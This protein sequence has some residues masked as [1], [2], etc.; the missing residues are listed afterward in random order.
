MRLHPYTKERLKLNIIIVIRQMS[1]NL[2][3]LNL[4]TLKVTYW[5]NNMKTIYIAGPMRGY[6]CYNFETF[7]YWAKLLK[8][9][10]WRVLNPAQQDVEKML[11]GWVY[12]DDKWQE[13]IEEDLAWIEKEAD[14]IFL[15]DG[16]HR[17]RGRDGVVVRH[18]RCVDIAHRLGWLPVQCSAQC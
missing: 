4:V 2:I 13:V 7:F 11:K 1:G 15:M 8:R 16:W 14:A 6:E 5:R 17:S 12:T 3:T 9:A 10:G 18:L